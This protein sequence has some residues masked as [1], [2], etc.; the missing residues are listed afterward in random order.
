MPGGV[1]GKGLADRL[2]QVEPDLPVIFMSGYSAETIFERGVLS[3]ST[4]LVKKP[5]SAGA[6]LEAVTD[7][8]AA[9]DLGGS[10]DGDRQPRDNRCLKPDLS[11]TTKSLSGGGSAPHQPL[12]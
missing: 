10:G 9:R 5:F 7:A 12:P 2:R 11:S 8:V 1:S 4:L 3:P 6:L